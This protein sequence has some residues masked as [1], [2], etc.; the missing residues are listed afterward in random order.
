MSISYSHTQRKNVGPGL[1]AIVL[2]LVLVMLGVEGST[3]RWLVV[4]AAVAMAG[5]VAF[6]TLFTRLTVTVDESDVSIAFGRGWP[7]RTI[8]RAA[9]V[10][11]APVRNSWW[12]GW[13][14]RWIPGGGLWNVWGLDAVE[15]I[16]D[17]GRRF[18]IGI[19]DPA[20]LDAALS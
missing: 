20:G 19:D 8:A 11:H 14:I 15:L 18:R 16:L 10:S 2:A 12:Y 6:V 13:G 4:L 5:L 1:L 17:N 3:P 7:H 9:I